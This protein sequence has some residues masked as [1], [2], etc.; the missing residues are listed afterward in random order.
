[1]AMLANSSRAKTA[2]WAAAAAALGVAACETPSVSL[3]NPLVTTPASERAEAAP[4]TGPTIDGEPAAVRLA[5]LPA[6]DL[7]DGECGLFLWSA[8]ASPTFVFFAN[9]ATGQAEMNLGGTVRRLTLENVGGAT[10]ARQYEEQTFRGA[11]GLTV[12]ASVDVG[13][14]IDGGVQVPAG[15]LTV[16]DA[17]GWET[18]TPVTG[19]AACK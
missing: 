2:A 12:R 4:A 16:V 1:M 11:G 5:A 13:E 15:A 18:V 10:F 17:A 19:V 7:A 3:R 8:S 14:E 9:G 6:Q